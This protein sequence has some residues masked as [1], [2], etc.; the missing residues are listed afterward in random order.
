M[1]SSHR[2]YVSSHFAAKFLCTCLYAVCNFSITS[3][4]S[5]LW[6]L[7]QCSSLQT[8]P[9]LF[10]KPLLLYL[11]LV[12]HPFT[13]LLPGTSSTIPWSDSG[14][15]T[16]LS[17]GLHGCL[18]SICQRW[19][20]SSPLLRGAWMP[21]LATLPPEAEDGHQLRGVSP[22]QGSIPGPWDHDLSRRQTLN[23]LSHPG[24]PTAVSYKVKYLSL[25]HI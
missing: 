8:P 21:L 14:V 18:T 23:R 10:H 11:P 16:A 3:G 13:C 25:I 7:P 12:W 20:S 6:G 5:P 15:L 9:G 2:I 19:D 1:F 4:N 24:A 17:T 22:T